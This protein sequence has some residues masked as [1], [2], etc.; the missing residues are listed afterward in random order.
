[1]TIRC[2]KKQKTFKKLNETEDSHITAITKMHYVIALQPF[3]KI[4]QQML[5]FASLYFLELFEAD[6]IPMPPGQSVHNLLI[7]VHCLS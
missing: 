2:W 3:K 1:M 4:L 6:S 5:D 7:T